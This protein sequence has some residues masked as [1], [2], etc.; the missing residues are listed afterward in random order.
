MTITPTVVAYAI[1]VPLIAWRIYAR[2]RR[3]VGRQRLSRVRPW[4][5]LTLFPLICALL[6]FGSLAHPINLALLVAGLVGGALLAQYGLRST[7][8]EAVAGEG[9][10]YTPN[11]PLG[12]ALSVL[13]LG[14]ILYRVVEMRELVPGNAPPDFARS[15][16]TLAIFGL[17]AGYYIAYAIG[18]VRWRAGVM[19]AKRE[20]ESA[21]DAGPGD[22]PPPAQ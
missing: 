14:R 12:I 16:L 20:R 22:A 1:A 13:F 5:T 15:P 19:K 21:N 3:A 9:F 17:L 2:F 18:L 10:F 11:A 4:I 7:R 6:A 8:F